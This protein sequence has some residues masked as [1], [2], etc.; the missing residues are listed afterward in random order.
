MY[1]ALEN[2]FYDD[3]YL[4]Q[5]RSQVRSSSIKLPEVH[6]MRKNLDPNLKPEIQHTLPKQGSMERLHVGQGRAGSKREKSNPINHAINQASNL[7][8]KIPGRT[9]IETRKTNHMHSTHNTNEKMANTNPLIPDGPFHPGPVYRPPPKPIK[10]NMAHALS[11]QSSNIDN[12]NSNIN[13]D[14]EENSPFQE[15]V[16]SETFQRPDISFFQEP[17]EFGDL[18]NKENIIYKHLPKQTDIDRI[19]E[20]I[21]RKVLKGTHLPVETEE[22][23]AG[24]IYSPYFKDL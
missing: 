11:S 13:F 19:L 22:I 24:Y 6:G 4:I 5:M 16:M 9:E 7:S 3:R 20:I 8:Q 2:K 21:Q 1:Q 12:N 23:Q 17:K 18:I 14:F 15:G 10:Q